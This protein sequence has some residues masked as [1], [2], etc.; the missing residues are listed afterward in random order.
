M[1]F[2]WRETTLM[3]W[4]TSISIL[5]C[6]LSLIFSPSYSPFKIMAKLRGC[7]N[8]RKKSKIERKN[9]ETKQWEFSNSRLKGMTASLRLSWASTRRKMTRRFRLKKRIPMD[10]AI[11]LPQMRIK[12]GWRILNLSPH[13]SPLL[14]TWMQLQ[15]CDKAILQ[16]CD[17][18]QVNNNFKWEL[19]W[20]LKR[21]D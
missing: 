17:W 16:L 8:S 11:P 10:R 3:W 5:S 21:I 15:N 6:S 2:L 12:V 18:T 20:L 19:L 9:G 1:A 4:T 7:K 13:R 14:S